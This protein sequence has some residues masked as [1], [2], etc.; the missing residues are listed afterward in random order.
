MNQ[1][2][3]LITG[4]STG[5]GRCCAEGLAKRGYRVFATARKDRD[6]AEL[7]AIANIEAL[8]LDLNRPEQVE[9]TAETVLSRTDGH[10]HALFNN[11]G[12]GQPGAVEDLK[13]DVLRQQF[14]TLVFGWHDLTVRILPAMR[15]NGEGRIIQNSSILGL[16]ALPMRGAYNSAK[17]AIEGLTDTL[18]LELK[19]SGIHVSLIEPGPIQSRFRANASAAFRD[20]ITIEGS[21]FQTRYQDLPARLD[22]AGPAAP[23]TLPPEAVFKKLLHALEAPKPKARYYVTWPTHL[24]GHLRRILPTSALDAVLLKIGADESGRRR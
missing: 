16:T 21:P 18:R 10:I 23:G 17:F 14:E 15:R 4:C 5:I 1:R 24:L 12:Y 9:Q 7:D 3:I 22:Q 8:P 6:L 19:G 13:R 11:G 20:N 2:S